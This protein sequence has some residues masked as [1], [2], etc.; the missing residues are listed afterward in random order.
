[1]HQKVQ[2]CSFW[3]GYNRVGEK[4]SYQCHQP[5][6]NWFVPSDTPNLEI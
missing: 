6:L 5:A 1:M 3:H 2:L 4:H